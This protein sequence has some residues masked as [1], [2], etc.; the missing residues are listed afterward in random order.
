MHYEL[1]IKQQTLPPN[2]IE[3]V[4]TYLLGERLSPHTT[5][6]VKIT[7]LWVL[8]PW[9]L[10]QLQVIPILPWELQLLLQ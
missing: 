2:G 9:E 7:L 3:S 1:C 10:L 8:Q 5:N 4:I 6:Q